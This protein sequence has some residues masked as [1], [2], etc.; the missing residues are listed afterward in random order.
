MTEA[1]TTMNDCTNFD[2]R[3]AFNSIK[4][5]WPIGPNTVVVIDKKLVERL[6][7][8]QENTLLEQILVDGGILMRV[9]R[10]NIEGGAC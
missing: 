8:N 7:I 10:I 1:H 9:K 4:K 5:P 6:G 2:I 3:S